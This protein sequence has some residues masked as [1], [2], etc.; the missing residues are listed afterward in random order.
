MDD[1]Y[2]QL[3]GYALGKLIR[4]YD[5][6]D[7]KSVMN[8]PE[9]IAEK[10][11]N[12]LKDEK[13]NLLYVRSAAAEALGI[14]GEPAAKYIPD[15]LKFLKVQKVD[16]SL[17]Y[18]A[19]LGLSSIKKLELKQVVVVLNNLY[20]RS[21][22]K[23]KQWR[24][25]TCF[26]GGGTEEIKTLLTWLRYPANLPKTLTHKEAKQTLQV[27]L[28]IWEPTQDLPELRALDKCGMISLNF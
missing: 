11:V 26:T 5:S 25:L 13:V 3:K 20:D 12:I 18:H 22:N 2:E 27:F 19:A 14:F 21:H 16:Q 24:F 23:F 1:G 9:K 15:I 28:Q 6:K 10:L 4:E 8:K 17:R 7:I